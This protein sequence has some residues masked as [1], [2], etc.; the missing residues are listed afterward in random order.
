MTISN[1]SDSRIQYNGDDSTTAFA[2]GFVFLDEGDLEVYVGNTLQTLTTH[3]TVSGG[4]SPAATGTV[5]MVTAPATGEVLTIRRNTARTQS[6]DYV[7]ND[8]FPAETH[9]AALDR[10]TLLVQELDEKISRTTIQSVTTTTDDLTLPAP[11]ASK[12]LKWN[13]AGTALENADGTATANAE[14]VF[15]DSTTLSS[16]TSSVTFTGMSGYDEYL[17]II[18]GA[19]VES[20]SAFLSFTYAITGASYL[21]DGYEY[22]VSNG[23]AFSGTTGTSIAMSASSTGGFSGHIRIKD[24]SSSKFPKIDSEIAYHNTQPS[25][26]AGEYI[27]KAAFSRDASAD[28]R[29]SVTAVKITV[30]SSTLDGGTVRLLGFNYPSA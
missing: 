1:V 22:I 5:T 18:D 20:S 27:T 29:G 8:A 9:E 24:G 14:W 30:N 28:R 16:G 2:T 19:T 10:L 25:V 13:S 3:Y 4:G 7:T 12:Y 21:T 17:I 15:I 23:G 11:A 26:S 6:T